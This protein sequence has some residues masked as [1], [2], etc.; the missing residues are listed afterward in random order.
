M[1]LSQATVVGPHSTHRPDLLLS[2]EVGALVPEPVRLVVRDNNVLLR[3]CILGLESVALLVHFALARG[4]IFALALQPY[5]ILLYNPVVV[6]A[7]CSSGRHKKRR[8]GLRTVVGLDLRLGLLK[9]GLEPVHLA[10][11][12]ERLRV[13]ALCVL[14]HV[15]ELHAHLRQ[16]AGRVRVGMRTQRRWQRNRVARA[17]ARDHVAEC[18]DLL[19]VR[20]G[21]G[22]GRGT[23][24]VNAFLEVHDG[25]VRLLDGLDLLALDL[26][27]VRALLRLELC[28]EVAR[29]LEQPLVLHLQRADGAEEDEMVRDELLGVLRRRHVVVDDFIRRK[30]RVVSPRDVP[31]EVLHL[32]AEVV[33]LPLEQRALTLGL[34]QL[35]RG[36]LRGRRLCVA[37]RDRVRELLRELRGLLLRTLELAALLLEER[38]LCDC[39][40]TNH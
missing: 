5:I 2:T 18:A 17:R 26:G 14:A 32:P 31:Q 19:R 25:A 35:L 36:L 38:R 37:L 4:E 1:L 9:L 7:A 16:P 23:L 15:V 28:A 30:R 40:Y 12:R 6:C 8:A 22:L 10:L 33:R 24:C 34:C 3:A 27:A 20:S 13:E 21:S 29:D 39:Q 11:R